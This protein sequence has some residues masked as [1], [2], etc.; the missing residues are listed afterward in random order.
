[1]SKPVTR[2]SYVLCVRNRGFAASLELRKLYRRLRDARAARQGLFRVVDEAG[3][4]FLYPADCFV[5]L[6]L[7]EAALRAMRRR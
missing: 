4:D 6:R 5:P 2:P 7:G 3:K 1:M